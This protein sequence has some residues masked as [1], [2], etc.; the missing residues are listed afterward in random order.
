VR[1]F[2]KNRVSATIVGSDSNSFIEESV[3]VFNSDSFVVAASSDMKVNGKSSADSL[4][5]SFKSTA[6]IN[7]NQ[8]AESDLQKDFLDKETSEIMI[9][10]V[11]SGIDNDKTGEIAHNIHEV[12]FTTVIHNFARLPVI[13]MKDVE[14]AAEGPREDKLTVMSNRTIGSEA[15]RTFEAP[16][17]N[18]FPTM[19]PKE[20][21]ADAVKGFVNTH[22]A[23]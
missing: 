5:E 15:V 4:E 9:G 2:D 22:V 11:V 19:E 16:I 10:S 18:D 14:R 6:V 7:D 8:T 23:G 20:P 1:S 3:E 12:V 13:D 21:K 17:G